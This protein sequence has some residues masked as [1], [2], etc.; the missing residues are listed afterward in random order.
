[1]KARIYKPKRT[2]Y[3]DRDPVWVEALRRTF[4]ECDGECGQLHYD[5]SIDPDPMVCLRRPLVGLLVL[6]GDL[7]NI[8]KTNL[9]ALCKECLSAFRPAKQAE[10]FQGADDEETY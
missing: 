7:R 4:C 1:M 9:R 3:G 2:A 5:L 8:S 6:D 10:L